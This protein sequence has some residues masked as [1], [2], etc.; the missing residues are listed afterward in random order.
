MFVCFPSPLASSH[1]QEEN[2]HALEEM[3]LG[4]ASCEAVS[5]LLS[6]MSMGTVSNYNNN[7]NTCI[8]NVL[9]HVYVYLYK[10]VYK[11]NK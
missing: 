9:Y 6:P 3:L 2:L 5:E 10:E 7:N 11:Q 4:V 1:F 8:H